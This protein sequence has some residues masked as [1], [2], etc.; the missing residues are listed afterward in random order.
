MPKALAVALLLS[1]CLPAAA[2]GFFFTSDLIPEGAPRPTAAAYQSN[3]EFRAGTSAIPKAR[4]Y[5]TASSEPDSTWWAAAQACTFR[6][7]STAEL[8][9]AAGLRMDSLLAFALSRENDPLQTLPS[10]PPG[11]LRVVSSDQKLVAYSFAV[12]QAGGNYRYFGMVH[13]RAG[14]ATTLTRLTEAGSLDAQVS[15]D[16]GA[17]P[18]GLIYALGESTYRRTSRYVAL[19]FRPHAREAQQKWIEPW[20]LGRP[21][22]VAASGTDMQR[23]PLYF[24]ARVFALKDFAGEHFTSPPK[25]LILRYAPEVSASL[26]FGKNGGEILVDEVAPMRHGRPGDF[27]TYGPTLAV[28]RLYFEGGKWVLAPVEN[29]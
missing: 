20:V 8:R 4:R 17:W 9:L 26:R 1:A 3:A 23:L 27:K 14:K 25:R 10:P 13:A 7:D 21:T 16:D 24:G 15:G 29:P 18:G 19:M 22:T 28:D 5:P 6:E 11:V 12:P 2:R